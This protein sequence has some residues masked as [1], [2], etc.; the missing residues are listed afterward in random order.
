[1]TTKTNA[2][3]LKR[4]EMLSR[5]LIGGGLGLALAACGGGGGSDSS[6]SDLRA[7]YEKIA[8]GMTQDDVIR[9]VGRQPQSIWRNDT[10]WWTGDGQTL[11]VTIHEET[12]LVFSKRWD[13][14]SPS[15]TLSVGYH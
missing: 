9:T 2:I 14:V 4:R 11:A 7:A 3:E 5:I 1:M 15:E 6:G 13:R 12:G 8:E 10:L